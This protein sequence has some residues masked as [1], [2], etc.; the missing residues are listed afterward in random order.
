MPNMFG[1]LFSFGGLIGQMDGGTISNAFAIGKIETIGDYYRG[2][3]IGN[4]NNIKATNVYSYVLNNA[5]GFMPTFNG[6]AN[7]VN[8]IHSYSVVMDSKAE[9]QTIQIILSRM[10]ALFDRTI[11]DFDNTLEGGHPTLRS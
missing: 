9:I 6:Y 11:W 1:N 7:N 4:S 8:A 3:L 5:D 10:A 2:G